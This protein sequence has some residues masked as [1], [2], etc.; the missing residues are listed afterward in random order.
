MRILFKS[1]SAA[2]RRLNASRVPRADKDHRYKSQGP[3]LPT[4]FLSSLITMDRAS[5][6]Q[7]RLSISHLSDID[8]SLNATDQS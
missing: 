4:A 1:P 2:D 7:V 6:R 5:E 8:F 3:S